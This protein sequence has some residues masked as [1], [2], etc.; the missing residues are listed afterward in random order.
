MISRSRAEADPV[1]ESGF[2]VELGRPCETVHEVASSRFCA[3]RGREI[4]PGRQRELGLG[5]RGK[6][7]Q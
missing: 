1:V 3:R 2:F 4:E 6:S 7:A 5:T